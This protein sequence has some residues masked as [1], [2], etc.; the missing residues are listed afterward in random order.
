MRKGGVVIHRRVKMARQNARGVPVEPKA[1]A[2][3]TGLERRR[4]I[5]DDL[6]MTVWPSAIRSRSSGPK[7]VV[8]CLW[9]CCLTSASVASHQKSLML[10]QTQKEDK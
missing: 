3:V 8:D 10:E 2:G 5:E 6:S 9:G 1:P 7:S 4:S